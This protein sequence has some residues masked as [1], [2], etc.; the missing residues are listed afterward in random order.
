MAVSIEKELT[1]L[2][3]VPGFGQHLANALRLLVTGVNQ[4][5]SSAGHDANGILP[6]PPAIQQLNVKSNGAGLVHV[7]IDDH[8]Q[9]SKNLHYFVEYSTDPTFKQPHVKPLQVSRSMDPV[10]LPAMDDNGNPQQFYF[11]AYSQY[12]GG[13][14]GPKVHFGGTN[15][16]A[17]S[18]GG[19]Q[20]M[21]LL[22]S[23]G[24]GTG[25]NS[26]QE[27]GVGFGKVQIRPSTRI[28]GIQK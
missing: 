13:D 21:T 24:S 28:G 17:V 15:P 2:S 25:Q 10:N 26:G 1:L 5:G 20:R 11:R 16:T 18:P 8:N 22:P 23:T 12:P 4:L 9:I 19:T 27:G 3:Q 6:P 7:T 14:P